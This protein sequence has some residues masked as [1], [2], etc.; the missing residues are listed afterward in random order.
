MQQLVTSRLSATVYEMCILSIA[1]D[2]RYQFWPTMDMSLRSSYRSLPVNWILMHGG[3]RLIPWRIDSRGRE[4]ER[5]RERV[6]VCV[7][8]CVCVRRKRAERVMP[9]LYCW[10]QLI[11][12]YQ[13]QANPF[14]S[15]YFFNSLN[16]LRKNS[17]F[18]FLFENKRCKTG[19]TQ[20][21]DWRS[22][23]KTEWLLDRTETSLDCSPVVKVTQKCVSSGL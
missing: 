12:I 4:R 22:N 20:D 18:A 5:E 1:L 11:G 13:M 15:F 21:E 10:R 8:V 14:H 7:C 19:W 3:L 6:C 16:S 2:Q 23:K 9:K 17:V